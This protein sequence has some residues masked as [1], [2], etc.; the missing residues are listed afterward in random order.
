VT[1]RLFVFPSGDKATKSWLEAIQAFIEIVGNVKTIFSDR[2][3]VATAPKF[4]EKMRDKYGLAW[5]FLKKGSK[6]YL[7]ER[8]IGFVKTKLSQ[9]LLHRQTKN[10]IQFVEPIVTEY[11]AEKIAGTD[12]RRRQINNENF[13][14]F[15]A[16]FLKTDDPELLFNGSRT[17]DFLSEKWNKKLFRFQLG[18]K[19]LLARRSNWKKFEGDPDH[20]SY[21]FLKASTKGGFGD[22]VFTVSGRQLRATKGFKKFVAVYSLSEMGPAFHF[23]ENDMKSVNVE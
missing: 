8:Y 5:Q 7:A 1:N 13:Y 12:F 23:Y 20:K 10:W 17:G 19:V 18:Q 21:T 22:K 2:D 3:S 4:L 16:Q 9:A 11:N 6:S 14:T 15:L